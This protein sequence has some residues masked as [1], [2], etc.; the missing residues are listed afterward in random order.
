[1]VNILNF[2]LENTIFQNL[3]QD[4]RVNVLYIGE[5]NKQYDLAAELKP[6]CLFYANGVEEGWQLFQRVQPH[7]VV[8]DV[9]PSSALLFAKQT[10]KQTARTVVI[11]KEKE[12]PYLLELLALGIEHFI[13]SPVTPQ[14]VLRVV[15]ESLC[16]ISLKREL[17]AQKEILRAFFEFQNDLLCIVEDDE[18]VDCNTTFLR[19][20][21]Y[22]DLASYQEENVTF[23]DHFI[24][25]HGYYSPLNKWMWIED[26]LRGPK[27]IK[28]KDYTG[29]EHIFLLRVATL[30]DD[31]T[32]FIVVC[33]EFTEIEKENK[34][35]ERLA[36]TD[37]LTNIYN[38][39]KFQ[40]FFEEEWKKAFKN[41]TNLSIILFDI[42]N[43]QKVNDTYGYDYGDLALAQIAELVSKHIRP[44][45]IFARWDGEEFIL[46][47]P[48]MT[49]KESF[50][51]AESL[52][53]FIETKK[54][55][56]IAKLTASF[57]VAQYEQGI[58][59][60]TLLQRAEEALAEAKKQGKNQVCL[61]RKGKK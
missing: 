2:L 4:L 3:L 61:Y 32:R 20:F 48:G 55:T 44:Q 30:P 34:E 31:G 23:A 49:G 19:F 33:T 53:F 59:Q 38:R 39:F 40:S 54:F 25:E 29:N 13:L 12:S 35:Y 41:K 5:G 28:M 36:A 47:I 15:H 6:K 8:L 24:P 56:G 27:K 45:D 22:E 16:Y 9:S 7:I 60:R 52:R 11:W 1:M 42:D 51:F 14:D 17:E 10:E 58:P 26:C 37:A 43:F 21:G 18:I 50:Q 57:G 46:L